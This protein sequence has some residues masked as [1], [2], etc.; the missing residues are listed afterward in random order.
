MGVFL[1]GVVDMVD[2]FLG[3]V[4][5]FLHFD[6]VNEHTARA[7]FQAS[8][9]TLT[10]V[11]LQLTY[12]PQANRERGRAMCLCDRMTAVSNFGAF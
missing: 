4:S 6:D 5:Y 3:G 9:E 10:P 12:C 11:V 2:F 8:E 7:K 1:G